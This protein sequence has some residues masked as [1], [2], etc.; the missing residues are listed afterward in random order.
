P[1]LLG[2]RYHHDRV[3]RSWLR[4]GRDQV[5]GKGTKM[6]RQAAT[7]VVGF[8]ATALAVNGDL[9]RRAGPSGE[10]SA[11]QLR[12][13]ALRLLSDGLTRRLDRLLLRAPEAGGLPRLPADEAARLT[14]EVTV[15]Q[16]MV[17]EL[18]PQVSMRDENAVR[19]SALRLS[20]L[21]GEAPVAL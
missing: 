8:L 1:Q 17:T 19:L 13:S 2:R 11:A 10:K 16:R 4:P 18:G 21:K 5:A 6:T 14:R 15:L 9:P 12:L 20:Q 3:R 7:L